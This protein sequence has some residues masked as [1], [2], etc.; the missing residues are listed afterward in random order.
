MLRK[1][2]MT[3]RERMIAVL[4]RQ[5]PDRIPM[6]YRAT[7]EA[8]I[9]LLKYLR[10]GTT[11]EMYER[12]H[13]DRTVYIVPK[14]VG[15]PIDQDK[16]M[17]GCSYRN[18]DY[19]TG[20]YRE[21]V[22]H[23]LAE[24]ETVDEI[25]ANY[26][27]PTAEWF[28][29]SGI[30]ETL[31]GKDDY[32]VSGGGWEPFLLYKN[33]RGEEQAFIDLIENP[34]I[35]RYCM[36]KLFAFYYENTYRILEKAGGK[37]LISSSGEDLG[38]Q[39]SLL[40]SPEHI[41]TYFLP[42]HKRMIE[43]IHQA[44]AYASFHSDGAIRKIIPDLIEIGI[45][46]LDPVQWRC[47]DMDREAL[48]RDFGDQIIFHGGMD[49]QYTLPFGTVEDVRQEVIDNIRILGKGGGYIIGP[50]HNIQSVGPA[51]NVVAMYETAYEYGWVY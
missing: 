42:Y 8:T 4:T 5:K 43:L 18:I 28:D 19:G 6:Y 20:T 30:P 3:P 17:F 44:G 15:P 34:D 36:E 21:C 25:D 31:K 37:V 35:V 22:G 13:I 11:A 33:M 46:I 41:R 7:E 48:K 49:N 29:Y 2:T 39:T 1:E 16:D 32:P 12:L 10:C 47:F 26:I 9:K 38:S 45:D 51:E 24:Y 27:W 50:C 14:Y 40:Y 23:P